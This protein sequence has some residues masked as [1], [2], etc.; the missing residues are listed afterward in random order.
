VEP[1]LQLR[2][3]K[4]LQLGRKPRVVPAEAAE[5]VGRAS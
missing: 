4:A 5:S 1:E 3:R 2:M